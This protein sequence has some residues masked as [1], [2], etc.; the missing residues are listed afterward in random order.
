MAATQ[1]EVPLQSLED[2]RGDSTRRAGVKNRALLRF[3]AVSGIVGIL[4]QIVMGQ[5]HPHQAQPN[6]SVAAFH[7]YADADSWVAVHI[8][9][10][11]GALLIAL[12]FVALARVLSRQPG[13]SGAFA[14]VGGVGAVV[15]TA[16]FAVQMAV[17]GVALKGA[18]DTWVDAA[19]AD[20]ASAFQVAD[21][22]RWIEKGLSGFF[23]VTNGITL[24]ALGLSIA[25]GHAYP[26][27]IGWIGALAGVGIIVGG[28]S[29]AHTGFSMQA[30]MILNV[31][32]ILAVLFLIAVCVTMWRS[33]TA[34]E[35]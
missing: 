1:R 9:Q 23:N 27:W 24:L 8:G 31:P 5:L 14:V 32:F 6:D 13:L 11:V 21:G 20:K 4:V 18:I 30:A 15:I 33:P 19:A 12:T 25:L 34:R 29:V 10:F 3:A 35:S 2:G 7:E 16:V 26:R 22:V 17:D 28:I